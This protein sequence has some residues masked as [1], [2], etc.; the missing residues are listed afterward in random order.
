MAATTMVRNNEMTE[1]VSG[2]TARYDEV[3]KSN[4][5]G[6]LELYAEGI[7]IYESAEKVRDLAFDLAKKFGQSW[8][9]A[10]I[11]AAF[12]VKPAAANVMVSVVDY[13][14]R[15]E[16][17]G[18]SPLDVRKAVY[19][20]HNTTGTGTV[21][22]SNA[23]AIRASKLKEGK[24]LKYGDVVRTSAQLVKAATEPEKAPK[25]VEETATA[26]IDRLVKASKELNDLVSQ[27]YVLTDEQQVKTASAK[28]R[29][30]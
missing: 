13:L 16:D 29:L 10:S 11:A 9:K 17:D 24:T 20:V 4:G 5:A 8:G 7:G 12:G 15:F 14:S 30:A 25:T 18:T 6:A 21:A 28:A 1:I 3:I 22:L 23:L 2:F 26:I 27:G 19:A